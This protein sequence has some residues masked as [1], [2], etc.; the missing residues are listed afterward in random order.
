P[1]TLGTTNRCTTTR[2]VKRCTIPG[3]RRD[4][5]SSRAYFCSPYWT[6]LKRRPI[7]GVKSSIFVNRTYHIKRSTCDGCRKKCWRRPKIAI[8][9]LFGGWHLPGVNNRKV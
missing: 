5:N 3:S 9:Y 2:D 6:S 7:K 1:I 8:T 4:I